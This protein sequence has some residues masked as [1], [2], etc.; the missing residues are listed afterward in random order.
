[1]A[2]GQLARFIGELFPQLNGSF[3]GFLKFTASAPIGITGLRTIYNQRN[4]FLIAT[5]P[6][7]DDNQAVTPG[8]ELVFPDIVS[9]GGYATDIIM[10]GGPSATGSLW[11]GS[12][13]PTVLST[14]EL[15]TR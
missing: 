14:T 10:Y 6:A 13:D 15:G 12:L 3:R 11:F 1:P 2:N 9:G 7:R 5:T 4:D 8:S